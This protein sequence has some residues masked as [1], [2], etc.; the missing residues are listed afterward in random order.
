MSSRTMLSNGAVNIGFSND[1]KQI[2]LGP[3]SM[4]HEDKLSFSPPSVSGNGDVSKVDFF[5]TPNSNK[6]IEDVIWQ[7]TVTNSSATDTVGFNSLLYFLNEFKF[8]LNNSLI[9]DIKDYEEIVYTVNNY[10]LKLKK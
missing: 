3:K 10:Y 2:M 9:Y 8:L 7:V 5:L 4:Y 1:D 6:L